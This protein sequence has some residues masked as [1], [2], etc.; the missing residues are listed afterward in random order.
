M[1]DWEHGIA[2]H[3]MQVNRASSLGKREV[4]WVFSNCGRKSYDGDGHS[5]LEFF[6][7]SQDTC[8]VMMDTS[9]I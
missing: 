1:F 3:G 5:K 8:L 9:G 4:S 2:L 6:Q 7:L